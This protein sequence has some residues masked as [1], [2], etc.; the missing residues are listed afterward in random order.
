MERDIPRMSAA[1]W[2]K[3]A[4]ERVCLGDIEAQV[5]EREDDVMRG[6]GRRTKADERAEWKTK[7]L[8]ERIADVAR[9]TFMFIL[10]LAPVG[11]FAAF[12]TGS[13]V[14]VG[15]Q[16][17]FTRELDLD[18]QFILAAVCFLI[19][20]LI[21]VS[22]V[23]EWFRGGRL[24]GSDWIPLVYVIVFASLGLVGLNARGVPPSEALSPVALPVWLSLLLSVLALVALLGFS[25]GKAP[26][27]V[28]PAIPVTGE[29]DQ[30]AVDAAILS[31]TEEKRTELAK[32]REL[33]LTTALERGIIDRTTF[34]TASHTDLGHLHGLD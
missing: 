6:L 23:T 21:P 26:K 22:L 19:A 32:D 3:N 25:K 2:I 18:V 4:D 7:P 11:G 12:L 5:F 1:N 14:N 28:Y 20:C 10:L 27:P 33:A 31:L 15:G 34:L 24:L 9:T 13:Q 29:I 8:S 30:D 17:I 16:R